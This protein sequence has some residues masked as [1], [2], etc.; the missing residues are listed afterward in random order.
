[1]SEHFLR[2]GEQTVRATVDRAGGDDGAITTVALDE[3]EARA[4]TVPAAGGDSLVLEWKGRRHRVVVVQSGRRVEVA[5]DGERFVVTRAAGPAASGGDS[6]G[7]GGPIRAPMPGKVVELAVSVGDPVS[8]GDTLGALEAMK[9]RT[10]LTAPCDGTVSA[11]GCAVGDQVTGGQVLVEI[12]AADG[13]DDD[14]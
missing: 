6:G 9:L 2:I 14:E 3:G 8:R 11:L 7:V 13:E 4:V 1:M 5:V 12:E 10:A